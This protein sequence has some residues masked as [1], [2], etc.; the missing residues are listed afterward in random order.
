MSHRALAL[1][2]LVVGSSSL[3]ACA[4]PVTAPRQST[5][6]PSTPR[7]DAFDPSSCK[8]GYILSEGRCA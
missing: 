2:A 8:N 1:F 3:T 7:H 5:L 6:A 4:E